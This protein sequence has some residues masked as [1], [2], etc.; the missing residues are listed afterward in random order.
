MKKAIILFFLII[1]ACGSSPAINITEVDNGKTIPTKIGDEISITLAGNTT[2]GYNWQFSSDKP[3]HSKVIQEKYI[4]EKHP[5]G[6]VGV[7]GKSIYQIKVMKSGKFVITAQYYRPWEKF[8][9]QKD[10]H[11]EFIFEAK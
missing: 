3:A 11:F 1:T 8:D 10:K 9:S 5:T 6:M 4:V 2:T 7:G